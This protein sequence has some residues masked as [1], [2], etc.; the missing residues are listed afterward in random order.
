MGVTCCVWR[1]REQGVVW[2]VW[3]FHYEEHLPAQCDKYT[4]YCGDG[5]K[6]GC[7]LGKCMPKSQ[8]ALDA[9]PMHGPGYTEPCHNTTICDQVCVYHGVV[10]DAR[11]AL[12]WSPA[13]S[14]SSMSRSALAC[15]STGTPAWSGTAV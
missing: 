14:K 5:G 15:G 11:T 9:C 6:A 10:R 1:G 12:G 7:P 13:R 8:Y 2:A 3:T 4:C